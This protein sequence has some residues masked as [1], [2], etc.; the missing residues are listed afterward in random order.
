MRIKETFDFEIIVEVGIELESSEIPPMLIQPFLENS[1]WHGLRYKED[2]GKLSISIYKEDESYNYIIKICDNGIGREDSAKL[3]SGTKKSFGIKISSERLKNF[4]RSN[5]D[6]IQIP[7]LKND[8]DQA[9]G[10]L[11]EIN[12]KSK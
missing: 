5:I 10:T 7:D 1:I 11:V 6:G 2:K 9:E 8:E 12:I 3:S 4:N